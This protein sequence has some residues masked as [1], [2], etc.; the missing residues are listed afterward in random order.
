M[1]RVT[2]VALNFAAFS[3]NDVNCLAILLIVCLKNNLL[4]PN[5]P[6]SIEAFMA[7]QT[8]FQNGITGAAQGGKVNTALK[9][10]ARDAL[11]SAMRQLAAYVQSLVPTLTLSQVLTSGFD[12]VNPNTTPLPLTQPVFTLDNSVTTQLAV[13]L[14][15]VKNAKAYQLQYAIGTGPWL[16]AGIYPNT[17]DIVL[18]NLT[19][20]TVYNVRIRAIGGSTQYSE[21]SA[22]VSLMAT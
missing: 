12:V 5:V 11:V 7:L 13:S 6:V 16:E 2:R 15:A 19:P 4:F 17:K 22:T 8:A 20:G 9:N 10:E 18:K 14:T 1:K 3:D 21:W